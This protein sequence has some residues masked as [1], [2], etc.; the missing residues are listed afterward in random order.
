[1]PAR[2][3]FL[4]EVIPGKAQLVRRG[5]PEFRSTFSLSEK[6]FVQC[7]CLFRT[8]E[9]HRSMQTREGALLG[10]ELLFCVIGLQFRTAEAQ[11][12]KID[13]FENNLGG[14]LG[15]LFFS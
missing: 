6:R 9:T 1:M 11:K 7:G 3:R 10:S 14:G 13:S 2:S 8:P 5:N 4:E 12:V 15:Q